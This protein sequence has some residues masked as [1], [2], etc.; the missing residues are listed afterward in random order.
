MPNTEVPFLISINE[1][2]RI[3]SLS[4]SAVNKFRGRGQFPEPVNMGDR[5]IAFVR[6]EVF[7]WIQARVAARPK[8]AGNDNRSAGNLAAA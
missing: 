7:R 6:D 1:V 5:R 4:R 8:V 2:C 3:S